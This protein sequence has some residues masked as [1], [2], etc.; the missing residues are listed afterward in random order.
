MNLTNLL[1]PSVLLA[2]ILV[3]LFLELIKKADKTKK[4]KG[5]YVYISV[6]ISAALALALGYG[7]F[8]PIKQVPFY[9]A[10]IF[11]ISTFG[12]EGIL[13][14]IRVWIGSGTNDDVEKNR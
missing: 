1:L 5:F 7:D 8:F 4:L 9:W 3:V 12:Y 6:L 13:K 2:V 11:A 14:K 10:V